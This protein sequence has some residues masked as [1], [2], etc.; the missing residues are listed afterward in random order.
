MPLF[1]AAAAV[2]VCCG[3]WGVGGEEKSCPGGSQDRVPLPFLF[4]FVFLLQKLQESSSDDDDD[5][6]E[7]ARNA[8]NDEGFFKVRCRRRCCCARPHAP[9]AALYLS[10][11]RLGRGW[12]AGGRL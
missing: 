10:R 9:R 6:G 8:R 2:R 12:G 11:K 5:D 7:V 1:A 3:W 4:S